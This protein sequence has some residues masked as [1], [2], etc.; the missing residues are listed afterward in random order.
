MGSAAR[1]ALLLGWIGL[2]LVGPPASAEDG[3]PALRVAFAEG[4]TGLPEL[5]YASEP[6]FRPLKLDLYLPPP[7]FAGPRPLVIYVH[8]GGW[9]VGT[10]RAAAVF[11][12]WPERLAELAAQGYVV[13]A[14]SYRLSG[15]ARFPAAL[16]DVQTSI[17]WLR[18]NA[19]AFGID[20]A[21][22]LVWGES[23]GGHLAALA[24]ARC[25]PR[26]VPGQPGCVRAAVVWYG[27]SD[28]VDQA[29]GDMDGRFLGCAPGD[30]GAVRR[31]ASPAHQIGPQA[32]PFLILHG[33]ADRVV[34][35]RQAQLL[36]QALK[37]RKVEVRLLTLEGIDHGFVGRSPQQTRTVSEKALQQTFAFIRQQM[38]AEN[39]E[40]SAR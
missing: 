15:E 23:A 20:P 19:A 29:F 34:P 2:V 32:P 12:H 4:V 10:P 5:T 38:P 7:R 36:E 22:V 33:T 27:I 31:Q 24:A 9:A 40:S 30:C 21:Q 6:G 3:Y 16:E 8:G 17:R 28:L 35:Y 14:P 26:A 25:D 13:A 18:A 11:R 1:L 37:A 39:P